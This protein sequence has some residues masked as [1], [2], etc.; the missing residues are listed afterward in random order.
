MFLNIADIIRALTQPAGIA[1]PELVQSSALAGDPS[2]SPTSPDPAPSCYWD[3]LIYRSQLVRLNNFYLAIAS[4]GMMSA[5]HRF[6]TTKDFR[7]TSAKV[8]LPK[9]SNNI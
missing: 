8:V 2:V 1:P 9:K 5:I 7:S 6:S 3:P 4:D